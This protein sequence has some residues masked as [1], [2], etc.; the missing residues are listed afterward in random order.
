ME[1]K[2]FLDAMFDICATFPLEILDELHVNQKVR[3]MLEEVEIMRKDENPVEVS[4]WGEFKIK[5]YLSDFFTASQFR[6]A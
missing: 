4:S 3:Q 5:R 6:E 2:T 1:V